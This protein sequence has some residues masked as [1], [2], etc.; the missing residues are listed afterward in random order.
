M[1]TISDDLASGLTKA[2]QLA[3]LDMQN[4][5]KLFN[6]SG[7]VTITRPDGST[8]TGASWRK[9]MSATTGKANAGANSDI[10]SL[11]GLT[12]PLSAS[13]GG[14]GSSDAFGLGQILINSVGISKHNE[15]TATG[16][17]GSAGD[18][19]GELGVAGDMTTLVM[20][21]GTRPT[22][23]HQSY[24]LK[25]TWFSYFSGQS[26]TYHEAYTTGNTTRGS[27]GSIKAA[28]P[29]A[30]IVKS[31]EES[32]RADVAEDGFSWCGCGTA[33]EEAEGITIARV[34]V[35][36]YILSGSDGLASSGWQMMPPMDPQG[37][38]ALGVVEAESGENGDITIRL[39]KNKYMMT[40]DGEIVKT[41]GIPLDVPANSWIDVRLDMPAKHG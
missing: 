39:Y 16:F 29:I 12:T 41:K 20:N 28:S 37:S 31:R 19:Y 18:G 5:D 2:L 24:N 3:Q 10:T 7:D 1:A 26:W 36:V 25:R 13:Q 23:I 8:F 32:Q 15:N 17:Y 33:N 14:T 4:Q 40:D 21:R 27:D 35:G 30:R 9:M 34:D 22:R 11:S 6:G 38:G